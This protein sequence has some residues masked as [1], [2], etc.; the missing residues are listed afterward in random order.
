MNTDFAI[1]IDEEIITAMVTLLKSKVG[2][3]IDLFGGMLSVYELEDGRFS[4]K[5]EGYSAETRK[6]NFEYEELFDDA[7]T[8]A[9]FFER[10][11]REHKLGFDFEREP[12]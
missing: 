10:K 7:R 5:R 1:E 3:G 6:F 9:E 8:A 4:V 2:Y 12:V 11:R